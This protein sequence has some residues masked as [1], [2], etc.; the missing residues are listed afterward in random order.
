MNG[1]KKKNRS[2]RS[3]E[4]TWL[5]SSS[6]LRIPI[7]CLHRKQRRKPPHTA[8]VQE[9][10]HHNCSNCVFHNPLARPTL[11]H[12][13]HSAQPQLTPAQFISNNPTP[14]YPLPT[15]Q[16]LS[17]FT[18]IFQSKHLA[19]PDQTPKQSPPGG[20]ERKPEE[21]GSGGERRRER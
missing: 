5:K 7:G 13:T 12:P 15:L 1:R 10:T 14:P 4:M 9:G 16:P 11:P 19:I 17:L 3:G 6:C 2:D 20:R 21:R 18:F 8:K